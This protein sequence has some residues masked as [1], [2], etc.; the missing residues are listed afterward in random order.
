MTEPAVDAQTLERTIIKEALWVL[1]LGNHPRLS[2]LV[3]PL[4]RPPVRRFARFAANFENDVAAVGFHEAAGNSIADFIDEVDIIGEAS[5][6]KDGPLLLAANHP[7]TIDFL[8]TAS[9]LPRDDLKIVASNVSIVRLLPA[10][11]DHFIFIASDSVVGDSYSR[12]GALRESLRHLKQGGALLTFPS[13]RLDPDP[14]IRPLEAR[15][16]LADWSPSIALMLRKV[17]ECQMAATMVSGVLSEG[18]FRSPVTWYRKE[19]HYKQKVAELFQVMG[20]LFFPNW[21][22]LS[23]RVAFGRPQRWAELSP[24]GDAAEG[25]ATIIEQAGSLLPE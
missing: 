1:G 8:L 14:A 21:S 16:E 2:R 5:L 12:M 23:P 7:G 11:V 10:T 22:K 24:D 9:L 15:N 19:S 17:P 18:W 13:G 25:T 20:Q 3:A 4:F 6:P